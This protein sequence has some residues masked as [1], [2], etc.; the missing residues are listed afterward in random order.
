V[1]YLRSL[2]YSHL[3]LGFII[4]LYSLNQA[5]ENPE[6]EPQQTSFYGYS[7]NCFY[8]LDINGF[9]LNYGPYISA[10]T[11]Y[12]DNSEEYRKKGAYL[13]MASIGYSGVFGGKD[14]NS[15]RASFVYMPTQARET[16]EIKI[17]K[18]DGSETDN[19]RW[20]QSSNTR[21]Y[22]L[23]FIQFHFSYIDRI[24]IFTP[25]ENICLRLLLGAGFGIGS[26]GKGT[27]GMETAFYGCPIGGFELHLT[28]R[29]AIASEFSFNWGKSK[30]KKT[31]DAYNDST[32]EYFYRIATPR[33]SLG[34]NYYYQN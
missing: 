29:F 2:K 3:L 34:I 16:N 19:P 15:F 23:H 21:T 9:I 7:I 30:D 4:S 33:V 1:K 24:K 8:I 26:L 17:L 6:K 12:L 11:I 22:T 20:T 25:N 31:R 13:S 10:N 5:K 32:R 28:K 27:Y 14:W 18:V